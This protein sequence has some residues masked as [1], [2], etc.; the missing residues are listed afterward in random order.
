MH[1]FFVNLAC[2]TYYEECTQ[3]LMHEWVH[4]NILCCLNFKMSIYIFYRDAETANNTSS[5]NNQQQQQQTSAAVPNS[6]QKPGGFRLFQSSN[7]SSNNSGNNQ[8]PQSSTSNA[9]PNGI[10]K[11]S[12]DRDAMSR[13][14]QRYVVVHKNKGSALFFHF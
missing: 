10:L 2:A 14:G 1:Y 7:N 3:I 13:V 8:P 12:Y 9:Q 6:P 5:S 11:N 4:N